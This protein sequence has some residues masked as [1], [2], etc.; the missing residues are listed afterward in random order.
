[1]PLFSQG[2]DNVLTLVLLS[3][4]LLTFIWHHKPRNWQVTPSLYSIR[5]GIWGRQS[6]W[7]SLHQTR[8]KESE[9][10]MKVPWIW[11]CVILWT[12]SGVKTAGFR[13]KTGCGTSCMPR[14]VKSQLGGLPYLVTVP[15]PWIEAIVELSKSLHRK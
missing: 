7:L 1:M 15:T 8:W 4:F 13:L 2:W 3:N 12:L 10:R 6:Q 11:T 5:S 14:I 9:C